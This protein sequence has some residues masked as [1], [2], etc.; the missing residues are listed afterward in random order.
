MSTV[1][2]A[3]PTND[4][5]TIFAHFGRA[6]AFKIFTLDEANIIQSELRGS[7][8]NGRSDHEDDHHHDHDEHEHG[9][10]HDHDDKFAM[11]ADCQILLAGGM[12]QPA[13]DR[14]QT[15]GLTVILTGEKKIQQA[16]RLYQ[17]GELRNDPRRVHA[18]H[19]HHDDDKPNVTLFV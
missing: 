6:E 9:H 19:H 13:H 2:L 5:Q 18:H 14:L 16:L 8:D 15:M 1:K 7:L 11:V 4:G 10:H 12:G 17:T 3:V